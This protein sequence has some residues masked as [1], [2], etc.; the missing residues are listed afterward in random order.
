MAVSISNYNYYCPIGDNASFRG[1][2]VIFHAFLLQK[3][4]QALSTLKNGTNLFDYSETIFDRVMKR[5][6]IGGEEGNMFAGM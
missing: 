3:D 1:F 5:E 6:S 2:D 4:D